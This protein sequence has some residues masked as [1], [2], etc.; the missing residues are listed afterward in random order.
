MTRAYLSQ[1]ARWLMWGLIVSG[2]VL[3]M[4]ARFIQPV[5]PNYSYKT[6]AGPAPATVQ[7]I[8]AGPF[9]G[10]ASDYNILSVF[11]MYDYIKHAPLDKAGKQQAWQQLSSYLHRAQSLDPWF[12][13]TYRLTI[14]LLAFS[15][16]FA[17]DAIQMLETGSNHIS[18]DWRLPFFAGFI[19]YDRLNDQKKAFEFMQK[20]ISRPNA[21][22]LAIGLASRFLQKEKGSEASIIFLEYMLQTMPKGYHGPIKKRIE[23]LKDQAASKEEVE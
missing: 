13:D 3:Y 7:A 21:P 8:V 12:M 10:L 15:E 1:S 4:S 23:K 6:E 14:G 2:S 18:W 16:G 19:A 11:T 5:L 9:K 20:S 22:P 17:S